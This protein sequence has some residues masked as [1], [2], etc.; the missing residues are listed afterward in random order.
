MGE[1]ETN[2]GFL[3][4]FHIYLNYV[5]SKEIRNSLSEAL[6]LDWKS[7][8]LLCFF[9]IFFLRLFIYFERDRD[10]ASRVGAEREGDRESQA[11]S[12]LSA[13][14]PMRGLN[15]QNCEIMT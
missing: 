6:Y 1:I 8:L 12:A 5:V 11:D 9:V 3:N 14:S 10:S 13:R 4:T 7:R 2:K 15:S